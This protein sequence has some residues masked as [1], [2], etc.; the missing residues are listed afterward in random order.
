MHRA[1]NF[2][3]VDKAAQGHTDKLE[4]RGLMF[5]LDSLFPPAPHKKKKHR[6]STRGELFQ[7]QSWLTGEYQLRSWHMG[8]IN[9]TLD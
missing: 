6:G 8:V 9:N 5:Q 1:K 4:F 2:I 7:L 3:Y